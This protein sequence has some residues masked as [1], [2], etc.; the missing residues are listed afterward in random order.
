MHQSAIAASRKMCLPASLIPAVAQ[1]F[2]DVSSVHI[3]GIPHVKFWVD[4][5]G[6]TALTMGEA[7]MTTLVAGSPLPVSCM[8]VGP[9]PPMVFVETACAAPSAITP[10]APKPSSAAAP[11]AAPITFTRLF[12]SFP[13]F[14]CGAT[15]TMRLPVVSLASRAASHKYFP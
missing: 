9:A 15:A 8:A 3:Y 6:G 2:P 13:Y 5:H 7:M 11:M 12:N 14:G 4:P 10:A 1:G